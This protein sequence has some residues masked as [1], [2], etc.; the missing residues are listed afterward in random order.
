MWNLMWHFRIENR[1]FLKDIKE[2]SIFGAWQWCSGLLLKY[3]VKC[4]LFK[5]TWKSKIYMWRD[6]GKGSSSP[7]KPSEDWSL[8]HGNLMRDPEPNHP[9]KLS[10]NS[11]RRK[12]QPT[13]VFLPGESHRQRSLAGYS[14]WGRR[15]RTRLSAQSVSQ[16][17]DT[18]QTVR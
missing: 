14:P 17:P 10:L 8:C 11:W 9:A 16:T 1:L 7:V 2:S 15:S 6:L 5:S 13:P 4:D 3:I 12:W 18:I